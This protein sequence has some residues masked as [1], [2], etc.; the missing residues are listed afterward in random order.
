MALRLRK[1]F[2]SVFELPI[3][4]N[5]LCNLRSHHAVL[6]TS[7]KA[8][9]T[10]PPFAFLRRRTNVTQ[11]TFIST[12]NNNV[13]ETT[14]TRPEGH[15]TGITVYN[16]L[17]KNKVPLILQRENIASW[18]TCGPTVYDSAHIGHA[19]TYVRLDIIHRILREFFNI[20]VVMV[21][22]ITDIDDK[23][24]NRAKQRNDNFQKLAQIYEEEF[25]V[26][27]E[28][29][30]VLPATIYTRVTDHI[31]QILEFIQEIMTN[32]CAYVSPNGSV[33]FDIQSFGIH[34]YAKLMPHVRDDPSREV[35]TEEEK[36]HPKD[37]A[38]WKAA[39][40]GEPWWASPWG[41]GR[42]GWHIE[43][44]AMS[45]AIFGRSLDIH[46]GGIDLAF[47]H[48]DN[49]IAQCEACHQTNQWTNY[50]LHAGFLHLKDDSEKMSKSIGNTVTIQDFLQQ[51]TANQFRMFCLLKKYRYN[52]E[53]SRETM[54]QACNVV[55]TL[56]SFLNDADAYVK[57]HITCQSLDEYA[58]LA[59]LMDTQHSLQKSLADDFDTKKGVDAILDLVYMCNIQLNKKA[60]GTTSRSPDVIAAI[61]IYI[62]KVLTS[63][64]LEMTSKQGFNSEKSSHVLSQV[65]DEVVEFRK[66]VRDFALV[67][68]S[69]TSNPADKSEVKE[70]KKERGVLLK[71]CDELRDNLSAVGIQIKDRGAES[72][73]EY[74]ETKPTNPAS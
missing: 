28:T 40:S 72:T 50:F 29:L 60:Q 24:I 7:G 69:N 38:L 65:M 71:R 55:Q 6:Q 5:V 31:P 22:G 21:M 54:Q 26:D 39:K 2:K 53:Y 56:S 15:S 1:S 27:M 20:N 43:C 46:T 17:T 32:G 14:W 37:F 73:W 64:G 36:R 33:Y 19:S 13:V 10:N 30:K 11:N 51:Y 8:I 57:G 58:L 61:A 16:S 68:S 44:S 52:I 49:E 34:R 47:P 48:H 62:R 35:N 41:P 66:N 23:I 67:R 9:F 4:A 12:A 25:M 63:L 70:K 45:S 42:P 3:L 18:Y 59:K 74:T